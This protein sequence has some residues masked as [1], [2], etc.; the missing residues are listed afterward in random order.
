V[1]DKFRP[2]RFQLDLPAARC[3]LTNLFAE[4]D[5]ATTPAWQFDEMQHTGMDF[6]ST[7][8]VNGYDARHQTFRDVD[9]ENDEIIA[10]LGLQET[11]VVADF[12]CGTGAFAI[13]AAKKCAQ[14]Y[15]IDISEPMLKQAE[16][17]ARTRLIKNIVFCHGGFLTYHH[18]GTPLDA[19]T[20]SLALHHLP[21]FWKQKALLR[22]N[23]MLTPGGRLCL[24]D[25][26]VSEEHCEANIEKWIAKLNRVSGS[27]MAEAVTRHIRKEHST[28]SWIVEG[29]LSRAGFT[30]DRTD[31]HE[32]VLARYFCT[33]A[34]AQV[35]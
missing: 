24:V 12:G 5:M 30:I 19:I 6:T 21:D 13:K 22:L 31:Y 16:W 11:H 9:K 28:F 33:K 10:G 26:V 35:V 27:E 14:V 34:V 17:L 4:G 23:E 3:T 2:S 25:V 20:T 1:E 7:P 32:G 29:L 15:A 18:A 8:V